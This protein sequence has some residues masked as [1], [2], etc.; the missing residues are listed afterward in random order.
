MGDHIE[1]TRLRVHGPNGLEPMSSWDNRVGNVVFDGRPLAQH[2]L[3]DQKEPAK[4]INEM[5]G[6]AYAL[7]GA[8]VD[9]EV[10]ELRSLPTRQGRNT[11]DFEATLVDG[12]IVRV[13]TCGLTN[14]VEQLYI[15]ALSAIGRRAGAV[16]VRHPDVMAKSPYFVRFYKR[17]VGP[18][19]IKAVSD[20]LAALLISEGARARRTTS[21]SRVAPQYPVLHEL[22]TN[23]TRLEDRRGRTGIIL[24][25][26]RHLLGSMRPRDAFPLLFGEKAGKYEEYSEGGAVPVWLAMYVR[27]SLSIPYGDVET[28]IAQNPAPAPFDRLIIGT[29]TIGKAF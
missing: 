1:K 22:E 5:L 16:L 13:E 7:V 9:A 12:T 2:V 8:N 18:R 24:D 23:W 28:L 3:S 19:D 11:A 27:S 4:R 26:L 25:P 10:R 14:E 21:M 17:V 29:K 20:E 6:A 15:N